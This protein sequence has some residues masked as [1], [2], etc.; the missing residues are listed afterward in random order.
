L[1]K[2]L[3]DANRSGKAVAHHAG[4]YRPEQ[5]RQA[6]E[7]FLKS[8]QTLEAFAKIWGAEKKT[9]WIWVKRYR[10]LGPKGLEANLYRDGIRPGAKRLPEVV[11]SE[12]AGVKREYPDFGLRKVR[13]FLARFKAVK[14][15]TGAIRRT[16]KEAELPVGPA[17][18]KKVRKPP[19]LRRFERAKPMQLWQS[20]ITTLWLAKQSRHV[21]LTVF[22]DDHSRYVVSWG[23]QLQQK[24]ELVTE[25]LLDGIQRFGKPQEVLTDQGRQYVSWRGKS[26]FR[27]LLDREGIQHVVSR[28]HHPETL[29]KCERFW[30]TVG[31]ELWDRVMPGDL[32]EAR[33]RLALFV[34]HYNHFRP[35]QGLD[36]MVPADR[37]FGVES[38][39]RKAIEEATGKNA[40]LIALG[41]KPRTPVFLVGQIGDQRLT[42]HGERGKLVIQTPEG[43]M[44][45]LSL[46]G[47]GNPKAAK[48]ATHVGTQADDDTGSAL[49]QG[50]E[51]AQE[52]QDAAEA[53]GAGEG[54]VGGGESRV[55]G[56]GAQGGEPLDAELGGA[57]E[58]ARGGE[59]AGGPAGED[60]AVEPAG[61]F[62]HGC[63]A[64]ASAQEAE[65]NGGGP[66]GRSEDLEEA[67]PGAGAGPVSGEEAHRDPEGPAG[68]PAADHPEATREAEG[69][70]K[71]E[72]IRRAS[73][74]GWDETC[75]GWAD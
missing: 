11:R 50:V 69:C 21:Y 18:R 59:G 75:A 10:E 27:K 62:G 58:P 43:A 49:P 23:L 63:G 17:K 48:G 40:L 55:A 54:A 70:G 14:V 52:L 47:L 68:E 74:S 15:S 33:A 25:A 28:T 24:Q 19:T 41:E 5:R 36:G 38:E 22:M 2:W 16:L 53:R 39:V 13:D 51:E 71:Q 34:Q 6:V 73:G 8:G 45:T 29:G 56:A 20:D 30:E 60:L 72:G 66:R 12:I 42:M 7:A 4:P 64:V 3:N 35:H 44:Q 1:Y 26:D 31:K 61:A 32:E 9:L 65:G 46:D 37:F 57:Q 67:D